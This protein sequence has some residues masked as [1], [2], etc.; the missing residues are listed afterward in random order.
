MDE[1]SITRDPISTGNPIQLD[2]VSIVVPAYNEDGVIEEFNRRLSLVREGLQVRSEVIFVNDGSRDNTLARLRSLKATDPTIG[3]VD[4]SRNFGKEI[5]LTAGIDHAI[6]DVVIV[7]DADLQDPPELIPKLIERWR[8]GDVDMIYGQRASRAG[9]SSVKRLTSY[10]FY[11]VFNTLGAQYIPVDTGD[12]RLLSRR[13]VDAL[14]VL[15][16][17]HRF[18]KGLFGWIGFRQEPMI[19]ERDPRFAGTTKWNYWKLWNFSIEGITSFS[20]APLKIATYLG[21]STALAAIVYG[22]Y[23]LLRT[24]LFGNPVPGYPSLLVIILFI[25]GVQLIFL[26]IIGEYL[27]RTF[28]EVKQ[29]PLYIVR[30]WHA[31]VP[32]GV[33]A[34]P[35]DLQYRD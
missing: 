21:L 26:G 7:I 6:G 1:T 25:G 8:A 16:E 20:I 3:I 17:R 28:D 35:A 32:S 4:L 10:A 14:G 5:A 2:L 18:M 13:A 11:R 34:V 15:R 33:K 9:E 12:F 30:E 19:Y 31:A 27:G 22:S 29:R 24:F 23:I